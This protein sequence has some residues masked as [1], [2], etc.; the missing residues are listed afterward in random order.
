VV[1]MGLQMANL[2]RSALVGRSL[3]CVSLIFSLYALAENATL[4][5]VC[6]GKSY[7]ADGPFP[8]PETFSLM[9]DGT[10]SVM[11][12]GPGSAKP[13]QA[14]VVAKNAIQLKFKTRNLTGEYFHF[15]GDLF[16]IHSDGR[17]TR[18]TCQP[19]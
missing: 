14:P 17:L 15:T 7:K 4:N 5:L 2:G 10:K 18:L 13:V 11:I 3:T 19:S 12:G 1:S 8:T 9:I 16:L 6:S